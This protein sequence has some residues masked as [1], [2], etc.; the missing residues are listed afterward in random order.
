M[1]TLSTLQNDPGIVETPRH[2]P[3]YPVSGN[4]RIWGTFGLATPPLQSQYI[5]T[6]YFI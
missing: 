3:P 6:L 5:A 2:I 4:V 1:I